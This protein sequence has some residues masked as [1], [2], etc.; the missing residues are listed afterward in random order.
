MNDYYINA[1]TVL[2]AI[3]LIPYRIEDAVP[4]SMF[5][6]R[7]GMFFG[8]IKQL[9]VDTFL[10][11]DRQLQDLYLRDWGCESLP[12]HSFVS[13]GGMVW[14]CI[15]KGGTPHKV[16]TRL[17]AIINL[18][19]DMVSYRPNARPDET[20]R[21]SV[22][23]RNRMVRTLSIDY[24]SVDVVIRRIISNMYGANINYFN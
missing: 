23:P 13:Q 20:Y 24:G 1:V 14:A 15:T 18:P 21:L 10:M 11:D 8:E 6:E 19:I 16:M 3:N 7:Y 12:M 17:A 5:E 9:D 4:E 2:D 22:R